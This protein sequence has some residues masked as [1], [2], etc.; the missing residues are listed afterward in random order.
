MKKILATTL[1]LLGGLNTFSQIDSAL[2]RAESIRFWEEQNAHYRDKK[3]S[4]LDKKARKIFA[5]HRVYGYD[6]NYVIE[7][8][9]V[10]Y[11]RED[12]VVMKTSADTEKLYVKYAQLHFN[13]NRSHCHLTVY[14]SIAL[15]EMDEYK[16]YLFI[17]FK[18]LTSGKET[19]GGG[20]YLDVQIPEGN[21][22]ILNFNTAYNPYCAYTDGYF[23][24]VPPA[25]NTLHVEVKAGAM[26]PLAGE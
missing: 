12:T 19:Y 16:N 14:Q 21:T 20:R 17:P 6:A 22:L 5:G 2:Y 26:T 18:D 10:R 23:C 9:M 8:K 4:P 1:I 25:E 24:P 3:E 13:L 15:R 11:E 7:A